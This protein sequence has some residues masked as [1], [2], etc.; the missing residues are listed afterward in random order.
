[1]IPLIYIYRP[2]KFSETENR[3]KVIKWLSGRGNGYS[4]E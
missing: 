4:M 2:V 1:M 3:I